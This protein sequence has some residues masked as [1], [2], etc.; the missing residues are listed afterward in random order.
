MSEIPLNYVLWA[1]IVI[2]GAAVF[3][4]YGRKQD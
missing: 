1:V 2:L 3:W 4:Y